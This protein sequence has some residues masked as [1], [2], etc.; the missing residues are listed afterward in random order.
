MDMQQGEDSHLPPV[1]RICIKK[2]SD[3]IYRIHQTR[4]KVALG[5]YTSTLQSF[6]VSSSV[7]NLREEGSET[8]PSG[9]R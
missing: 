9:E 4:K 8:K 2:C 5:H 1:V 3:P 7:L 6:A